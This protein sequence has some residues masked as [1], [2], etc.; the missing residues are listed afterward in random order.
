MPAVW[1]SMRVSD[2]IFP[3]I[4]I[5]AVLICRHLKK[6]SRRT[7]KA[8]Y[9]CCLAVPLLITL[10][11]FPTPSRFV[12]EYARYSTDAYTFRSAPAQY[13]LFGKLFYDSMTAMQELTPDEKQQT[14]EFIRNCGPVPALPD[15]VAPRRNLV[16]IMCESLEG[17]PVGLTYEGHEITPVLNALI[18]D[19]TT[20][21]APRVLSQAKGGRSIDGQLI[22]FTGLLPAAEG[23]YS[24]AYP[25]SVFP[26]LQQ[27]MKADRGARSFLFTGDK[28]KV[29][30][31]EGVASHLMIDTLISYPDFRIEE[32]YRSQ[33]RHVGDRSFMRQVVEKLRGGTTWNP[34]EPALLQIVT[35]SGHS[36]FNLPEQER[37]FTLS[38]R[39]PKLMEDY[40]YVTHYVDEALGILID[41]LRSRPDWEQTMVVI[42]GDHEGLAADRASLAASAAGKGVV[43]AEPMVPLII[44]NSPVG[45]RIDFPVGQQDIYPTILQLLGLQDYI[46]PG[47]GHSMLDPNHP[48]SLVDPYGRQYGTPPSTEAARLQREA[49]IHSDRVLKYNLFRD[50]PYS[51]EKTER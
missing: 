3:I 45:G 51:A 16:V 9:S 25:H 14:M 23:T 8:A 38:G 46:W 40:L 29:W 4:T 7:S 24:T 34:G 17:W 36:P 30:N 2:L 15:S 43:D 21:Y 41:Y 18:A 37:K 10:I 13:T 26:S 49:W 47:F 28:L 27:A 11:T 1:A 12:K 31:Q 35:Y 5:A 32:S 19:S 33:R 22:I 42:T 44:L 20:L 50:T 6:D 39:A 48:H